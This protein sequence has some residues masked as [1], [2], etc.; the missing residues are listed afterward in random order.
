MVSK[1][2]KDPIYNSSKSFLNKNDDQLPK[3][4][5]PWKKSVTIIVTCMPMFTLL[6]WYMLSDLSEL[7]FILVHAVIVFLILPMALLIAIATG[8]HY[9]WWNRDSF[10]EALG[11]IF[12]WCV[13]HFLLLVLAALADVLMTS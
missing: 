12:L 3:V 2:M 11:Y 8:W 7:D 9:A 10:S 6:S 13:T 5:K 4:R 1:I